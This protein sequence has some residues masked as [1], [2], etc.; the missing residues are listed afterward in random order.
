MFGLD[1]RIALAIFA[2]LAVIVG[3]AFIHVR[4]QIDITTVL[5]IRSEI[6]KAMEAF[7]LDN[8]RCTDGPR[9][10]VENVYPGSFPDW[11]GPYYP[12][13]DINPNFE[14]PTAIG[15]MAIVT[16]P[17][18][19]DTP[20]AF[21]TPCTAGDCYY[22]AIIWDDGTWTTERFRNAVREADMQLDGGTVATPFTGHIRSDSAVNP[23][24]MMFPFL[25][26][27]RPSP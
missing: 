21:Y 22:Y 15:Q 17:F 6:V 16:A 11:R 2:G 10:L 27:P 5:D 8:G 24:F 18:E 19:A 9:L 13:E 7:Q 26:C 1:A 3:I 20:S 25:N 14:I 4:R 12:I 23:G